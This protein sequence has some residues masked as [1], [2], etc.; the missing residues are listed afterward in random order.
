MSR[1]QK[2]VFKTLAY[3]D[4]FD[5]PLTQTEIKKWL[6]WPHPSTP[7]S[8]NPVLK[9]FPR[10]NHY[11]HLKSRQSITKLRRQRHRFSQ[12][13]WSL[14]RQATHWLKLIPT[15]KLIA[16]TGAL[17]MNNSDK[18]DDIDLIIITQKNRLWLTRVFSILLLE[19]LRRRR[20]PQDK[21]PADKICLNLFLDQSALQLPPSHRN[22]YTAH[23]IAQLKPLYNK[24]NTYQKFLSQNSWLKNYLPHA[25]KISSSKPITSQSSP[26]S[27]LETLAFKLQHAYMKPKITHEK[28]TPH[29]AFFHPRQTS[30]MVLKKY[31]QKLKSLL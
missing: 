23:E 4:I 24:D 18:N 26:P 1:I 16:V 25:V 9:T 15:I 22:L 13:K 31:R 12:L 8:L 28:V 27:L 20:R 6:I 5:Y 10:T 17:T 2:A 30:Q 29:T 11:Y 21:Q 14:A 7:P 3:A 19:L